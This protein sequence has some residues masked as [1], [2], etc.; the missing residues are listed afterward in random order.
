MLFLGHVPQDHNMYTKIISMSVYKQNRIKHKEV[1]V[2]STP[3]QAGYRT[4]LLVASLPLVQKE[5]QRDM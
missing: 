3:L 1:A 4:V 5:C 2:M